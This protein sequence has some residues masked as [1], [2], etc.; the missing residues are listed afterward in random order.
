M[1]RKRRK[2]SKAR[3]VRRVGTKLK[4]RRMKKR[5]VLAALD[6]DDFAALERRDA[7]V[8]GIEEVKRVHDSGY[9]DSVLASVP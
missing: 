4:P 3:G 9:V 1:W 5:A 2:S 8:I 6:G 7:P